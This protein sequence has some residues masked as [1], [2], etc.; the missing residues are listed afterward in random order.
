MARGWIVALGLGFAACTS[1]RETAP[2][3]QA[4]D[5]PPGIAARVADEDIPV[6]LVRGIAAAQGISLTE[7]RKRAISDA[8]FAAYARQSLAGTGSV[9]SAQRS[10]LSRAVLESLRREAEG[11]GPPTDSEIDQITDERWLELARPPL[12][13]TTHAAVLFTSPA[14]AA[15]AKRVADGLATALAGITDANEFER[16]AREFSGDGL[17]IRVEHLLP[18]APDGRSGDPKAPPGT[19]TPPPLEVA[20]ARAA[21]AIEQVGGHSPVVQTSYGYHVILLEERLP[22]RRFSLEERRA[23]LAQEVSSRRAREL[24]NALLEKLKSTPVRLDRNVAELLSAV[25]VSQ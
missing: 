23:M 20:Y 24:E 13:K 1:S 11:R 25:Q 22:E 14:D 12:V 18:V 17:E 6:A 3:D 5:L 4:G 9:E 21:H 15:K 10:A 19:P 2:P 7:A 8:L 16:R